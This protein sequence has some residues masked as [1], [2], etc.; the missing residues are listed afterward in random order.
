[1]K[2]L[3]V[4]LESPAF[5]PLSIG[6]ACDEE[7]RITVTHTS[8]D[9]EKSLQDLLEKVSFPFVINIENYFKKR[10]LILRL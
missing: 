3:V 9:I 2:D 10:I 7:N 1:M 8:K 6:V 5:V 4:L